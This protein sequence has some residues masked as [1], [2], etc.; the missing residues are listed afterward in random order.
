MKIVRFKTGHDIAYGLAEAAGVT[1][2][3]GSPFVAPKP[4]CRGRWCSCF[5]R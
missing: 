1:V 2:Y 5:P 3:K 4:W